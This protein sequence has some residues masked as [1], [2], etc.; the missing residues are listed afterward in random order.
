M[1]D[2]CWVAG[3]LFGWLD[4]WLDRNLD[5]GAALIIDHVLLGEGPFGCAVLGWSFVCIFSGM[6]WNT[7]DTKVRVRI[8]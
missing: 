5:D 7:L 6:V 8:V 3:W 1:L 2:F 4:Y